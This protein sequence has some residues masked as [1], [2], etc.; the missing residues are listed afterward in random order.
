MAAKTPTSSR[1]QAGYRMSSPAAG[2]LSAA[3]KAKAM[4]S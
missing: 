3:W 1:E 4:R 2:M